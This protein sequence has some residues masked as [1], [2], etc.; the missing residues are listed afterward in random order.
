MRIYNTQQGKMAKTSQ[1]L[2]RLKGFDVCALCRT[3]R[4]ATQPRPT[5]GF[6]AE[7][8]HEKLVRIFYKFYSPVPSNLSVQSFSTGI[9]NCEA[10]IAKKFEAQSPGTADYRRKLQPNYY[11]F[12][13]IFC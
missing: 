10:Q 12:I 13:A 5:I 6:A 8:S 2:F 7:Q 3:C 9:F 4:W 11:N 1:Y